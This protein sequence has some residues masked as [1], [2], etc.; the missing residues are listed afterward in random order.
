M[1]FQASDYVIWMVFILLETLALR[2]ANKPEHRPFRAFMA[3]CLI[4]DFILLIWS[5]HL[6]Y[7]WAICWI[8]LE[9]ELVAMALLAGALIGKGRSWRLPAFTIAALVAHYAFTAKWPIFALPEEIFHFERNC[10]L[11]ILGTLLVG[12]FIVE[13]AQLPLVVAVAILA[14]SDMISAQTFLLGNYS[15]MMASVVWAIGLGTLV[16]A[17]RANPEHQHKPLSAVQAAAASTTDTRSSQ[18][19]ESQSETTLLDESEKWKEWL[20]LPC[21]TPIQ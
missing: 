2:F 15:P 17:L 18:E 13:K 9:I 6:K 1:V 20:S 10:C 21:H 12:A 19:P 7:Y 14:V 3:L 4:R 5:C 8:G 11:I 16:A